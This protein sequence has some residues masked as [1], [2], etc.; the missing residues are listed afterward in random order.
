MQSH[1]LELNIFDHEPAKEE[2]DL[3]DAKPEKTSQV[4]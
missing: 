1:G 3:H 4:K 2:R